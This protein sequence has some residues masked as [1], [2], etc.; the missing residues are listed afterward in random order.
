MHEIGIFLDDLAVW[1]EMTGTIVS[2]GGPL[3]LIW[4]AYRTSK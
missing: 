4:L 2:F 1:A 3:F